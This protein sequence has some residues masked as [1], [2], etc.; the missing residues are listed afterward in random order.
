MLCLLIEPFFK[1]GDPPPAGYLEWHWWAMVQLKAG[2][3][4]K[5]CGV[6]GLWKFPQEK[7]FKFAQRFPNDLD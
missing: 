5:E 7:C 4:Q 3:R 2:L 1:V 6:C